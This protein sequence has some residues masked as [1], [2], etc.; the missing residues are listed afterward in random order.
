VSVVTVIADTF[1]DTDATYTPPRITHDILSDRCARD[2]TAPAVSILSQHLEARCLQLA[3]LLGEEER[4]GGERER[5]TAV[6]RSADDGSR[7]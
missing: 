4:G 5:E 3:L 6:G 1:A 2:D 7:L